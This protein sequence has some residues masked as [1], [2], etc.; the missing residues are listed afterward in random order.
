[1]GLQV[2]VAGTGK[3]A[4]QMAQ[5]SAY[6]LILM[7]V[8]MPETDGL[9]ATRAIRRLPGRRTVPILA[10]TANAFGEDRAQCLKAGMNDHIGKPVDPNT[11]YATLLKWLPKRGARSARA[12]THS[13]SGAGMTPEELRA[14]LAGV[15][16][17]DVELYALGRP[18]SYLERLRKYAARYADQIEVLRARF[19]AGDGVAA[20]RSAHS[21]KSAAGFLGATRIQALAGELETAI[22]EGRPAEE[23]DRLAVRA[24]GEQ[25]ALAAAIRA[26]TAESTSPVPPA[27]EPEWGRVRDILARLEVL[28]MQDDMQAT[29]LM[30]DSAPLLLAALGEDAGEL[31]RHVDRFEYEPA[32]FALRAL[33]QR[34]SE[35]LTAAG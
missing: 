20:E 9:D 21:L 34:H 3:E 30:R 23:V 4:L 17:L 5:R 7:D 31:Q 1:V 24:H 32:L 28:L 18:A 22:H 10:M 15:A 26:R 29:Q 2:D 16:G 13:G 35:S 12:S 11:L 8:Q 33:M 14:L 19:T 27:A 25:A 6:D